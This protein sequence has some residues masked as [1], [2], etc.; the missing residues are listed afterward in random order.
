MGPNEPRVTWDG[1]RWSNAEVDRV[2]VVDPDPGWPGAFSAE[3]ERIRAVLGPTTTP[4]VEHVGSTAIPG[5]SAKPIIDILLMPRPGLPWDPMIE[6]LESIGYLYWAQNPRSDRM[7]FVKGM[8][9]F[10]ERR[11]HHVH[12]RRGR[13]ADDMLLFRDHLRANSA[14]A[15][16]YEKHKRAWAEEH[17]I[18][19]EA[20]TDAKDRFIEAVLA[21]ARGC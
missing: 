16:E 15:A 3:A 20:Y 13:D 18:D 17:P 5:L 14:V 7:F 12:V 6:P 8:P 19:R 4:R 21:K 11:T 2:E 10:G 9:P 1:E